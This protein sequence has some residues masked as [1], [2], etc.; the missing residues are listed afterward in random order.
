M[1]EFLLDQLLRLQAST[2]SF[3]C[4][5]GAEPSATSLSEPLWS[6]PTFFRV[7]RWTAALE[8]LFLIWVLT[9]AV[10]NH[11]TGTPVTAI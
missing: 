6:G 7:G 1:S 5:N 2:A 9:P 11:N 3:P 10:L 4:V 8:Q